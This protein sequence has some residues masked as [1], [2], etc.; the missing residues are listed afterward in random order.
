MSLSHHINMVGLKIIIII[1]NL[2]P[3]TWIFTMGY[4]KTIKHNIWFQCSNKLNLKETISSKNS[5][6][7]PT[8]IFRYFWVIHK[9]YSSPL[10]SWQIIQ[11]Q[12]KQET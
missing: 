5:G 9:W 7:E 3:S 11:G 6:I 4:W 8:Q 12:E 1:H 10:L 2:T